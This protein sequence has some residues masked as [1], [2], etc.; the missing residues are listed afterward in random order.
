MN[1]IGKNF[2]KT[3]RERGGKGEDSN[4]QYQEWNSVT[5]QT[6]QITRWKDKAPQLTQYEIDNFS[7]LMTIKEIEFVS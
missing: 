4:N 7:S 2:S 3:G 5:L 1:K 6:M